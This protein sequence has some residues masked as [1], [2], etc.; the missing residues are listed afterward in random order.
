MKL[1]TILASIASISI[2]SLT[3]CGDKKVESKNQPETA[4]IKL[5][6]YLLSEKPT[7]SISVSTARQ[8]PTPGQEVTITGKIMGTMNPIVESAAVIVIGDPT[9]MTSCDL[10]HDD[11]CSTPWDVCCDDNEEVKANIATIQLVDKNGKRIKQTLR[12]LNNLKELSKVVVKGTID[13][14]SSKENLIIN[15]S[16]LYIEG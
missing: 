7:S 1:K 14:S 12:G 10:I 6:K 13:E 16:A 3:S 4:T 8:N 9:K 2:L 11:S 5:S 15:A